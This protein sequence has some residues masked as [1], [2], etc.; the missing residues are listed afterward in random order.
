ML[1]DVTILACSN[2]SDAAINVVDDTHFTGRC[3]Y[4]CV[5]IC[6][7]RMC[8]CASLSLTVR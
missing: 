2:R 4:V 5:K 1:V 7:E 3:I 6:I 8:S